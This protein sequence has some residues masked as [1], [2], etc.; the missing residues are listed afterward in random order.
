MMV[1]HVMHVGMRRGFFDLLGAHLHGHQ[2]AGYLKTYAI[3]KALE[4]FKGFTLVFLLG[5]FLRITP[6]VNALPQMIERRQ[7]GL[8]AAYVISSVVLAIAALFVGLMVARRA[9][10]V[11][12]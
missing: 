4:Q 8:A 11:P 7:I 2:Q 10:G 6:Q 9:F 3:E 12:A 5:V 1:L